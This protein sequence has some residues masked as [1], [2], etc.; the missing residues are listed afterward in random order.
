MEFRKS[1][2][3]FIVE[4]IMKPKLGEGKYFYYILEKEGLD[5]VS[6]V[7][8]LKKENKTH[9][10]YSGIKDANARTRQWICSEKELKSSDNRIKLEFKGKGARRIFVGMHSAN[11]FTVKLTDISQQEAELLKKSLKKIFFPN[12]FDEQRFNEKTLALG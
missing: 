10:S 2:A 3:T 11:K 9:I 4:E 8:L 12:Y 7:E 1:P 5:S 6:A